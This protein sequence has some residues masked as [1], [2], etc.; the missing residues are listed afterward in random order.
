MI[1]AVVVSDVTHQIYSQSDRADM[2]E[3]W[4]PGGIIYTAAKSNTSRMWPHF[5]GLLLVHLVRVGGNVYPL[6]TQF[7]HLCTD[8]GVIK[9]G[10]S[11]PAYALASSS[12]VRVN[13]RGVQ[14]RSR[15]A[16]E[17][18][19][20]SLGWSGQPCNVSAFSFC[21]TATGD[22]FPA[23][24]P[25]I[26]DDPISLPSSWS[27]LSCEDASGKVITSDG[28]YDISA[29][30]VLSSGLDVVYTRGMVFWKKTDIPLW[31][32]WSMMILS[33]FVVR[34]LAYNVKALKDTKGV[35]EQRSTL[36]ATVTL[37]CLVV[38]QGTSMY[39]TEE[40]VFYYQV[41]VYYILFYVA[42]HLLQYDWRFHHHD[43]PPMYN[44]IAGALNLVVIRLYGG[45][46]S[47]YNPVVF[48]I[49]L[50]RLWIKIS[51]KKHALTG[52]VDGA[53]LGLQCTLGFLLPTDY[54]CPLILGG[55]FLSHVLQ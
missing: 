37:T 20:L 48:M 29:C 13:Y 6:V 14:T 49:I 55:W 1:A 22:V 34:T 41:T 18:D 23:S 16:R 4:C 32:Y 26:P 21:H 2:C 44:I 50:T 54:L 31:V 47:P 36:V 3:T 33:V 27:S 10:G 30:D 19:L 35:V 17:R 45:C 40:D 12:M 7:P 42:Y 43:T 25:R 52:V 39:V 38:G 46:E 5:G 24:P 28:A 15:G 11:G 8:K 53:Y 9:W 51:G